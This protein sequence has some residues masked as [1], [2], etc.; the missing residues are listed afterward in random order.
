LQAG[1][2]GTIYGSVKAA[3]IVQFFEKQT[4][5]VLNEDDI[6]LPEIKSLGTYDGSVKL[7]PEVIGYF[8]VQVTK[9]PN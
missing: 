5:R 6:T 8:K 2:S 3:D 1:E 7:H 4:G 9:Q